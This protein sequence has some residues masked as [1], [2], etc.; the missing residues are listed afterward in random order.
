M[1]VLLLR[2]QCSFFR[3]SSALR[4]EDWELA[5][6]RLPK[7]PGPTQATESPP[8]A[9]TIAVRRCPS[10]GSL[11]AVQQ[12]PEILLVQWGPDTSCSSP[13]PRGPWD[14]DDVLSSVTVVQHCVLTTIRHAGL[15]TF[16]RRTPVLQAVR[17]GRLHQNLPRYQADTYTTN[18]PMGLTKNRPT[19]AC[20]I[21]KINPGN[22]GC[23]LSGFAPA[24]QA[25]RIQRPDRDDF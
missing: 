24:H 25:V 1:V 3:P 2:G 5:R 21:L 14:D 23:Q 6:S 13:K 10:Q 12:V 8:M 16:P 7:L 18:K 4:K 17:Q 20:R 9:V 22:S 19:A 15:F 11:A